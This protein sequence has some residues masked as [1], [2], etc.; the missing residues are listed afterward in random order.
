MIM[1]DQLLMVSVCQL[2]S[3]VVAVGNKVKV[4]LP[5]SSQQLTTTFACHT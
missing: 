2:M 5:L 4:N 1:V 3:I